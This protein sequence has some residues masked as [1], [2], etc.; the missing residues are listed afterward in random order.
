MQIAVIRKSGEWTVLRDTLTLGTGVTRSAAIE[1]AQALR[2][3][4][5]A[6]GEAVEFIVQD[7]V[8]GLTS[9]YSGDFQ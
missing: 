2:Y 5:E 8:G 4:A 3:Q 9:R 1:I 7:T 6:Q